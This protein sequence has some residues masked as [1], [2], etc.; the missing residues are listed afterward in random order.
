M[1]ILSRGNIQ[2]RISFGLVTVHWNPILDTLL[3]Q[4]MASHKVV[5][6]MIEAF[7]PRI[8]SFLLE[9]NKLGAESAPE[10]GLAVAANATCFELVLDGLFIGYLVLFAEMLLEG[11]LTITHLGAG[12]SFGSL[13]IASP[14]F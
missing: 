9:L 4:A 2:W 3:G 13:F 6:N 10:T 12:S 1:A 7:G 14:C 11:L 5:I 8:E